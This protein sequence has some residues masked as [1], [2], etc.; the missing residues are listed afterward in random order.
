MLDSRLV[1]DAPVVTPTQ[2]SD[3]LS[4]RLQ[5]FAQT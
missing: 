1:D 5:K 2:I 3:Y 4:D